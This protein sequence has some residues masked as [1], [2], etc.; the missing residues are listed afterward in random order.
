MKL[1]DRVAVV[2]AA[3]GAGIGQAVARKFAGEGAHVVISDAHAKRVQ[4][5][6]A[7]V[8][9]DYGCE[10][11]AFTVDV[12]QKDQIES[13]VQATVERFGRIDILFNNAGI[14]KLEPV[15]EMTDETWNLVLGVCLT[16][17]FYAARAVLPHMIKQGNGVI[18]NM[19]SVAGWIASGVGQ[20]HYCAAKAGVMAFTRS[21]AAEA[22]KYG[23]RANAI[24]PGVIYNEFL[25]RIYPP[26]YFE[27]RKRQAI[28]GRLG[29]PADVANLALFLA[30][31]DSA[32]ITGE[33]FCI[34]GG[35]TVRG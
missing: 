2:T 33:V 20:A 21:V 31:D 27:E 16:G 1:K 25:N 34:S 13:M 5:V 8:R 22:G 28:L 17:T 32:Y 9:E 3:A 4:E 19:A 23:V 30:S 24:A 7:K 35:S 14:N 11:P 29:E 6:A 12:R 10:V 18:I 26:G 15:W